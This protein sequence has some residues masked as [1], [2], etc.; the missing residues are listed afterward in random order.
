M[1]HLTQGNR[2]DSRLLV[3]KSQI[4][5]LTFGPSFG[6]N[7]CFECPNGSCEP[8][9]NIYI[10]KAFQYYMESLNPVGFDPCNCS[11]KIRESIKTPTPKVGVHFGMWRFIPSHSLALLGA[12]NVTP[13]L[14][15]DPHLYKPLPWSWAHG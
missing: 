8:T 7:L 4:V 6:H 3:V 14:T 10:P 2:D 15:H 12:W 11:L 13:G 1:V 5:N 9:L